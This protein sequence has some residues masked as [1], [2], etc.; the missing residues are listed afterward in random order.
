M[1][2]HPGAPL[3]SVEALEKRFAMRQTIVGRIAGRLPLAVHALNGVD[4]AVHRGETLGI[5]GESG[6]GKSTLA[7]CLV[8]L[9]EPNE[10]RVRFEGR[11]IGELRGGERR[12]FNRR[13]QMIFQDPYSSLNP[14][15]TV[16]QIL[17]E[18]LSVHRMR[19][20][21]EI[22]VRIAE[23]L[24]LVRLP[25]DAAGR[26]PHEFSGGQRQRIGIARALAVEPDVLVA[27]EL[28]SALDVS[29]QAQVVNLLLQL[30]DELQLTIVFVAHDLRLV[31]HISHRVAVMYLG[32]VIE[33]G[34]TEALFSAPRHP[35][36]MALLDAAPELD[37]GR[38]TRRAATRGELPSPV[39]LPGG[40]LF[41]TRC[42]HVF[43]RCQV[44]RPLLAERGGDHRA[45]CHLADFGTPAFEPSFTA[46][47]PA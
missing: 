27:D 7:R 46:A 8:R 34:P 45:A 29:V 17:G 20:K 14:R 33:I 39:D 31:R 11:D 5:V 12:A 35:Y 47:E 21:A 43:E 36:T 28:V 4:L 16:R 26:Y 6:C 23:L 42:P 19:P 32:K 38:R 24:D 41:N 37:P 1:T 3:I 2:N 22:P 10:G 13:V 9:L 30:Q 40:C 25:Q 18:A 44:E 15:M